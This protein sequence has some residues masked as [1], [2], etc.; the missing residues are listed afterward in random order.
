M[1][2]TGIIIALDLF[3]LIICGLGVYR[4]AQ[5]PAFPAEL[6]NKNG[7]IYVKNTSTQTRNSLKQGDTILT[8]AGQHVHSEGEVEFLCNEHAIGT[9]VEVAIMR[10]D[11]ILL[12]GAPLIGSYSQGSIIVETLAG[13]VFFCIGVFVALRRNKDK[14]VIA[15]HNL[16]VTIAALILLTTGYYNISPSWLGYGLEFLFF[17]SYIL[18]PV[19]FVRFM[20]VF[21]D[22]NFSRI[23]VLPIYFIAVLLFIWIG[24]TFANAVI[25]SI[26]LEK[27]GPYNIALT[28]VKIFFAVI[29]FAGLYISYRSY[30]TSKE[31]FE[32]RKL[33]WIFF[34]IAFGVCDY[35]FLQLIPQ[36]I[37]GKALVS[38]EIVLSISV[39]AP[40]S[41]AIALVRYRIFDVN[42]LIKR[43]SAYALVIGAMLLIYLAIVAGLSSLIHISESSSSVVNVV[44]A[45]MVALL[46]GPLQRI[47]QRIIDETFFRVSYNFHE[48]QQNI[49]EEIKFANNKVA[50]ANLIIER[51][52]TILPVKKVGFFVV[53]SP[54]DKLRL[55]SHQNF[56]IIERRKIALEKNALKTGL[57]LP[58]A[59]Q[60]KIEPGINFEIADEQV[61]SRWGMALV[62]PMLSSNRSIIGF[63]VLGEKLSGARF[64]ME[65]VSLLNSVSTQSGLALER[66]TVEFALLLQQ[67]ESERLS[68]LNKLKSYF[69]S[70]VSHDL[71][72]PLTSIRL[73]AELMQNNESL[74]SEK[75]NEYLSIIDG[76]ADRLSRLITNVLDFAKIEKGTKDY[77]L[78]SIDL[79][80]IVQNVIRLLDYQIQSNG[81]QIQ[82][83]LDSTPLPIRGESDAIS[84]VLINLITNAMKYSP[85]DRK[86]IILSTSLENNQAII[87]V[88]DEGYGMAAN[89]IEY[90]FEPFY[91]I[92]NSVM[93][94][95]GGAGL[96]LSLVKHAM[97]GHNGKV[98]VKSEIGKGSIFALYFPIYLV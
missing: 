19:F 39:I 30:R 91:R 86:K 21:S 9:I 8:I 29:F 67:A 12:V 98:E 31:E 71:K 22:S 14:A 25:P 64:S 35:I 77:R 66:F 93:K 15:F 81:F 87:R 47:I 16:C 65:D 32:Q 18:V 48:A 69:V 75:K 20:L 37:T 92:N 36:I 70:S 6:D 45:L 74:S 41:F 84:D 44:S 1:R 59:L 96:G 54:S 49:L 78:E 23:R 52:Q 68:E 43:T 73:F 56:D 63:L 40:I 90:I 2:R 94:S 72:T 13:F 46:F 55:L 24:I 82:T 80:D 11:K 10:G 97:D 26:H 58:V 3:L 85:S 17:A 89:E 53:E 34:G 5:K 76:E 83:I 4:L 57:D 95:A 88:E 51:I 7:D 27:Y 33:R 61:F 60:D 42:L 28:A 38:E 62:L 50:L 79:N